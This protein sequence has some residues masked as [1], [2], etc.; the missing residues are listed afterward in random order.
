MVKVRGNP[1]L[2][3]KSKDG[4]PNQSWL[5]KGAPPATQSVVVIQGCATR[6][7]AGLQL[8]VRTLEIRSGSESGLSV[9]SVMG[10]TSCVGGIGRVA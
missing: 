8:S 4:A 9:A 2:L 6:L 10:H 5:F 7:I 3:E 1:P